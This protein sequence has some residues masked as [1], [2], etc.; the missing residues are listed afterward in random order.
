[1][2]WKAFRTCSRVHGGPC[3]TCKKLTFF[4]YHV[5]VDTKETLCRTCYKKRFEPEKHA[6]EEKAAKEAEERRRAI[7]E[8][9]KDR[10]KRGAPPPDGWER[11]GNLLFQKISNPKPGALYAREIIEVYPTLYDTETLPS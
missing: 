1:M 4:G 3:A 11:H 5:N 6:A 10:R 8:D 2:S 9:E 7:I